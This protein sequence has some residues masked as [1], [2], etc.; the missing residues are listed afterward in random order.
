MQHRRI[1]KLARTEDLLQMR[2]FLVCFDF[3]T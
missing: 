1:P 3:E 2:T